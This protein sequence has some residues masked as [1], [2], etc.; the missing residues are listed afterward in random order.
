MNKFEI[1]SFE[2]EVLGEIYASLDA[3]KNWYRNYNSET[4]T[5]EDT[6]DMNDLEKIAIIEDIM[7]RI[8]KML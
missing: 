6:G 1:K 4:D 5:W 2:C 3:K 7:K 8:E